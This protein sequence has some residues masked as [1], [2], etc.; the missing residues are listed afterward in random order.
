MMDSQISIVN[1]SKVNKATV[2]GQS[3][4]MYVLRI[5]NPIV[6]SYLNV[7]KGSKNVGLFND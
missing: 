3:I 6:P 2:N 7:F 5:P 4:Q 1:N